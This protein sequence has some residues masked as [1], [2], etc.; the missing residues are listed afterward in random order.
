MT[1][2]DE[3]GAALLIVLLLVATLS[4]IALSISEISAQAAAETTAIR[5]RNELIWQSF[6]IET[7]AAAALESAVEDENA[8][9]TYANP[10][11]ALPLKVDIEGGSAVLSF[12]DATRCV[13]VNAFMSS[14]SSLRDAS[15]EL[16]ELLSA[17]NASVGTIDNL[18]AEIADWTD[19]DGFQSPNGAEDGLYLGLPQPYRTA[20]RMLAD[21]SELRA[22]RSFD[23]ARYNAVKRWLCALPST[24]AQPI[25]VNML[26]P[27]DAPLLVGLLKGQVSKQ[28]A[29]RAIEERPLAGYADLDEFWRNEAFAGKEISED[30]R[31]RTSLSSEFVNMRAR[32]NYFGFELECSTVFELKQG[33]AFLI[34]RRLGPQG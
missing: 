12:E 16:T 11:F 9:L 24:V 19:E 17:A 33:R 14:D 2:R 6:G 27:S 29:Q 32:L 18:V 25:N 10:L 4:F 3:R 34:S 5:A 22:I 23:I 26:R 31:K 8:R 13:N 7:V 21:R 1:R 15:L 30:L 20:G 28:D